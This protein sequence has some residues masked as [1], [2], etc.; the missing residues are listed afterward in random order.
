MKHTEGFAPIVI[1]GAAV[2]VTDTVP[3]PEHPDEELVTVIVPEYVAAAAPAGTVRISGLAA[4]VVVDTLANP[5]VI[6]AG[7]HAIEY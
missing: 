4:N 7:F 1:V 5:A 3:V 6:A 2:M